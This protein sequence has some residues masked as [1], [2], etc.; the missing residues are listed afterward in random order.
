MTPATRKTM[1]LACLHGAAHAMTYETGGNAGRSLA[2]ARANL[3]RA[4][5]LLSEVTPRI[6][7]PAILRSEIEGIALNLAVMVADA[8]HAHCPTVADEALMGVVA[9]LSRALAEIAKES[10]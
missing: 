5:K 6:N 2:D 8:M 1:Y 9:T 10:A 3:S 4:V 7:P